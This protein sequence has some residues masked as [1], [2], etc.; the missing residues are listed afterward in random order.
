MVSPQEKIAELRRI[1]RW[2]RVLE[3][4]GWS[5]M[6]ILIDLGDSADARQRFVAGAYELRMA[7]VGAT[8]TVG[9]GS[10]IAAWKRAAA[11]RIEKERAR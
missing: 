2:I 8:S 11:R 6:A 10:L 7:G 9:G 5:A 3:D 4:Q 1:V